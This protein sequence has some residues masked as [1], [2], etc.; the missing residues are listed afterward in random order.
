MKMMK[1]FITIL[2][3]AFIAMSALC[4][5]DTNSNYELVSC[6]FNTSFTT[7][8]GTGLENQL[9]KTYICL[10]KKLKKSWVF[11]VASGKE[12][13]LDSFYSE[14]LDSKNDGELKT[15]L[16]KLVDKKPE[17]MIPTADNE[18][19]SQYF[20]ATSCTSDD[21][22]VVYNGKKYTVAGE[23]MMEK[24]T[25]V[26]AAD[27]LPGF[28]VIATPVLSE[29]TFNREKSKESVLYYFWDDLLCPAYV[30]YQDD[31]IIIA[32]FDNKKKEQTE[33]TENI[34]NWIY[35][36]N[37]NYSDSIYNGQKCKLCKT[38]VNVN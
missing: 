17:R 1:R 30:F 2:G 6:L 27:K 11:Y 26:T 9:M 32:R 3:C 20:Y 24:V 5:R 12:D 25:Q 36:S 7:L 28:T 15:I 16:T 35:T 8:N 21:E 18:E 14:I 37:W 13:I 29:N 38:I 31:K 34:E 19:S 10:D 23:F 4:A 33:L 22:K